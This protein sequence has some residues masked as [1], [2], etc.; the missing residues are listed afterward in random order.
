MIGLPTG[1][2]L[3]TYTDMGAYGYWIGLIAG[4][5]IGAILLLGRLVKVQRNFSARII[6]Q[7]NG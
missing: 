5:A 3:A 4:L 1:Y 7:N 2:L 6:E